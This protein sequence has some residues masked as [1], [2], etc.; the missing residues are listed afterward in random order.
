M[1][2]AGVVLAKGCVEQPSPQL[3]EAST[4]A[5]AIQTYAGA[6]KPLYFRVEQARWIAAVDNRHVHAVEVYPSD[7]VFPSETPVVFSPEGSAGIAGKIV[8]QE[9]DGGILYVSLHS[10]IFPSQLPGRLK[11]ERGKLLFDLG[12]QIANLTNTPPLMDV[13]LNPDMTNGVVIAS[14]DSLSAVDQLL[15]LPTPWTRFL[16]G[17]PGSGKTYGLGYF[18]AR[19]I[20]HG[21]ASKILVVAP[22]NRAVDVAVE[23]LLKHVG[24][25]TVLSRRILRYGYPR[26]ASIVNQ[27]ELL[28]PVRLD[29]LNARVKDVLSHLNKAEQDR[30]SDVEIA[31]LRAKLLSAQEEVKNAVAE[32]VE[33]CQ[34]V[35]TTAALAVTDVIA[36]THWDT[37]IVDEVTMVT[38]AMC[39]FLASLAD[40]RLVLAGDPRRAGTCLRKDRWC[41]SG[42][43]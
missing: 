35:A 10:R 7:E 37:V 17:P 41:P 19:L 16:W 36:Q 40:R 22:S 39:M 15:D 32:H 30:L 8:G 34:V 28:G 9:P 27:P 18:I 12:S 29:A 3:A 11:I 33:Q 13:L 38:P 5:R 1:T 4:I 24:F 26:L 21:T 6:L 31:M 23:Q 20:Q 2:V 43:F 42:E 14:P 25:E